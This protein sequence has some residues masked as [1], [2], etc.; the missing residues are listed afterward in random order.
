MLTVSGDRDL[1]KSEQGWLLS[2]P[3]SLRPQQG[4]H[5]GWEYPS[6]FVY[7]HGLHLSLN[8]WNTRASHWSYVWLPHAL[9][10]MQQSGLRLV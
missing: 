6:T 7:S 9:A 5:K 8:D 1:D 3:Q 4:S 2:T 10:S